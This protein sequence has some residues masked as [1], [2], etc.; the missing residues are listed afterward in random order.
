MK[1]IIL[2][3]MVILLVGCASGFKYSEI[4]VQISVIWHDGTYKNID[5]SKLIQDV[6]KVLEDEDFEEVASIDDGYSYY[7]DLKGDP[8]IQILDSRQMIIN[9]K[10]YLLSGQTK[11]SL[12]SLLSDYIPSDVEE[13]TLEEQN[14]EDQ[15]QEDQVQVADNEYLVGHLADGQ[16]LYYVTD[17][18][19]DK[20]ILA[21]EIFLLDGE[22]RQTIMSG[23]LSL[24][25]I[26]PDSAKFAFVKGAGFEMQGQLYVYEDELKEI[27]SDEIT[28]L[29]EKS[30]TIKRIN[31]FND[32][33]VLAII[34][35]NSGTITK[36]GDAY[37]VTL[38]DGDLRMLVDSK[39]GVEITDISY[40]EG[41]LSYEVIEWTDGSYNNYEFYDISVVYDDIEILPIR[42][43][44]RIQP[45]SSEEILDLE[46]VNTS[47]LENDMASA[48]KISDSVYKENNVLF[49][50]RDGKIWR[51]TITEPTSYDLPR[52][53]Q[54][55]DSN[56][57]LM[58]K[59]AYSYENV[60]ET[61]N[62]IFMK[63]FIK[64]SKLDK[65]EIYLFK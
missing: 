26:S 8:N 36:G 16:S 28:A 31:W 22:V 62:G 45:L 60:I 49:E 20:F 1:K 30:R 18:P 61:E 41:I 21:S 57:S 52:G 29:P 32:D 2:L 23:D 10:F 48:E 64:D 46:F 15:D 39:E 34:G 65:I 47:T 3:L 11:S 51:Y 19:D 25:V 13:M 37:K 35:F 43:N 58:A 44:R 12:E 24:P 63:F 38:V 17:N 55:G 6:Y 56:E 54:V 7:L 33:Q 14:Q 5:D 9:D 27:S 53:I 59:F 50:F 40:K 4:A 42:V